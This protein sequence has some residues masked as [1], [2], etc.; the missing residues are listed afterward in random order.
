MDI[1][2]QLAPKKY[3]TSIQSDPN[4]TGNVTDGAGGPEGG[5]GSA[6]QGIHSFH[7]AGGLPV[8]QA[9]VQRFKHY[10][11]QLTTSGVAFNGFKASYQGK[12]AIYIAPSAFCIG[13]YINDYK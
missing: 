10:A 3:V 11:I 13:G 12:R 6:D 5:G 1:I 7:D 4:N 2:P 8:M 9:S